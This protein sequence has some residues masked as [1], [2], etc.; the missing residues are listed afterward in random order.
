MTQQEATIKRFTTK[1]RVYWSDC[2]AAGILYYA[3]FFR[4][5]EVAEEELYRSLGWPRVDIL[6]DLQVG[7]P[8]VETWAKFLKPARQGDLMEVTT[9]IGKRTNKSMHF[10]F[11]VRREGDPELAT[12]GNYTVVCV[13]RQFQP[14]PLPPVLIERMGDYL[15]PL[16]QRQPPIPSS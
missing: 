16:T 10:H 14:I 1:V 13:N 7:F 2:D 15:P 11:E 4:F 9:W 5:F 8:R 12:E 6:R 3:N